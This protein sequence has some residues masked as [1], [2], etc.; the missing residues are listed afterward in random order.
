MMSTAR[1][2]RSVQSSVRAALALRH[3]ACLS[4]ER[5]ICD[6]TLA[7]RVHRCRSSPVR[8]PAPVAVA[9]VTTLAGSRRR[10]RRQRA[11]RGRGSP[12]RTRV[13]RLRRAHQA[14]DHRAAAG[15]HGAGDVPGRAR[16]AAA[17]DWS[18][19]TLVGGTLAAGSANAL[20]C[21]RRPRHR[22]ADAPHPAPAA[23]PARGHAARR[24]RLRPRARRAS[25]RVGLGLTVN[26]LAAVLA[27][28]RDR[29]LRPRLHDAAQ[30]ADP[31]EHRAGA[32][33]PAAC[34]CSSAGRRSPGTLSLGRAW[35]CSAWC[36]SGRRRTSGRWRC[37]TRTTTRAAGVPMLPVVAT[38]DA[39]GAADR[40]LLLGDGRGVAAAVAGRRRAG[41]RRS[42]PSCSARCS[43]AR[44]TGC[45]GR[46]R[47]GRA[48][49]APMRLFHWSI[50]YL[51]LLF[52]AVAVDQLV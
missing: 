51:A 50:T 28:G 34:R 32:A 23:R 43:C 48:A 16:A 15:H 13:A 42:P 2:S 21:Y 14:A 45:C 38:P 8:R 30:A 7:T 44:R 36:S 46:V 29:L 39:G 25:R 35:C 33:R 10:A 37:G 41:L 24:A 6:P 49:S 47:R 1:R 20:N 26:W 18:L 4:L 5:R 19:A 40:R 12:S 11:V 17:V 31:A 22:R 27:D 52:L 9:R 3:V